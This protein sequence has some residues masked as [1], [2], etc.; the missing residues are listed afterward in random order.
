ML[1]FWFHQ[2]DMRESFKH[3]WFP[4]GADNMQAAIDEEITTEFAELLHRAERS[5]LEAWVDLGPRAAT[6]LVVVLDQFSRHVYRGASGR[7]QIQANDRLALSVTE[8]MLQRG[9]ERALPVPYQVFMLMP[10][11]HTPTVDRLRHLMERIEGM[12]D[13][14]AQHGLLLDKFRRQT[15]RRLQDLEGKQ[16][17]DGQD[18]LEFHPFQADETHILKHPL[19][20]TVDAFLREH[21]ARDHP[22]MAVSLS[23]G[24][25]SMVIAKLLTAL[26]PTHGGFRVAACHIDYANRPESGAEAEFVLDWCVKHGIACVVKRIEEL[27]RGVTARDQYEVE[28][29]NIR[30]DLY[31]DTMAE[32]GAPSMLVGHHRGDVQENIICNMF[33]GKSLLQING[34]TPVSH[35]N[36]VAV[37]RPM[38]AHDKAAVLDFAHTYGVPYF[39]DT[40]P[41]WSNR[42]KLRNQLMPLLGEIYGEGYLRNLSTLGEDAECLATMVSSGFLQPFWKTV[43]RS[44]VAVWVDCAPFVDQPIFFWKEALRHVCH[45]MGTGMFKDKPLY[46]FLD[47]MRAAAAATSGAPPVGWITM[48]KENATLLLG[49]SLVI[50]RSEVFPTTPHIARGSPVELGATAQYGPWSVTTSVV[51]PGDAASGEPGACGDAAAKRVT[52]EDVMAGAFQYEVVSRRGQRLVVDPQ[53]RTQSFRGLMRELRLVVPVVACVDEA[54]SSLSQ[55][56]QLGLEKKTTCAGGGSPRGP[57]DVRVRVQCVFSHQRVGRQCDQIT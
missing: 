12:T 50:F 6:A 32:T 28:T 54:P 18:I 16:W 33:K 39:K 34:M 5:E 44:S 57:P 46:Q 4:S 30:Y 7:T 35:V 47:R 11:R 25:D 2:G 3:K 45:S 13:A 56:G 55:S 42:G 8:T 1:E 9:W 52:M 27:T 40:T 15:L 38:L 23:G 24:V 19:A 21:G 22:A 37:W 20:R 36:R 41:T 49:T 29:R 14:H 26:S 10:L 17:T 53:A 43:Q 31:A 48:K 51:E